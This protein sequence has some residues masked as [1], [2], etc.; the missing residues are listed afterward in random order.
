MSHPLWF[1]AAVARD[2]TDMPGLQ[3]EVIWAWEAT[4][5]VTSHP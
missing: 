1:C 5:V 3:E 4:V 2:T